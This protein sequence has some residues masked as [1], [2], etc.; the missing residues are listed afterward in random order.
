[1][2]NEPP[3][4]EKHYHEARPVPEE[5]LENTP[6]NRLRCQICGKVFGT[7]IQVDKHM[8]TQHG[9]QTGF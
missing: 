6:P 9:E 1:M 2:T 8:Q 3:S 7:H 5:P 4:S